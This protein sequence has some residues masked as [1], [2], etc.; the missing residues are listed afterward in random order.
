MKPEDRSF[1]SLLILVMV[2]SFWWAEWQTLSALFGNWRQF[3]VSEVLQIFPWW[4]L[5]WMGV[6][7]LLQSPFVTE[8]TKKFWLMFLG[9][10]ALIEVFWWFVAVRFSEFI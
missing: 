5:A 1:R 8:A 10:M 3:S 2:G 6:V 7:I 4:V 9:T